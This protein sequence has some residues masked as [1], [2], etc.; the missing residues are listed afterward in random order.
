[1]KA[2]WTDIPEELIATIFSF[3]KFLQFVYPTLSILNRDTLSRILPSCP[4]VE[5][6]IHSLRIIKYRLVLQSKS[7]K[8]LISQYQKIEQTLFDIASQFPNIFAHVRVLDMNRAYLIDYESKPLYYG[9]I[10]TLFPNVERLYMSGAFRNN[11]TPSKLQS[12]LKICP[13]LVLVDLTFCSGDF[14]D[15]DPRFVKFDAVLREGTTIPGIEKAKQTIQNYSLDPFEYWCKSEKGII[16]LFHAACTNFTSMKY[17]FETFHY[18]PNK[19]FED[20][21]TPLSA[22]LR[23]R[24]LS[25]IHYLIKRGANLAHVNKRGFI[26]VLDSE[27]SNMLISLNEFIKQYPKYKECLKQLAVVQDKHGNTI[28]HHLCSFFG[29]FDFPDIAGLVPVLIDDCGAD[30]AAKNNNG[31]TPLSTL[32]GTCSKLSRIHDE[33]LAQSLVQLVDRLIPYSNIT[34][35]MFVD[36]YEFPSQIKW[37]EWWTDTSFLL[38]Q[39]YITSMDD[40]NVAVARLAIHANTLHDLNHFICAREN[41]SDYCVSTDDIV[42]LLNTPVGDNLETFLHF[43]VTRKEM[44]QVF[45]HYYALLDQTA[46]NAK[47]ETALDIAFRRRSC[48]HIVRLCDMTEYDSNGMT[49]LH[50]VASDVGKVGKR[51]LSQ[52][53]YFLN[54]VKCVDEHVLQMYTNDGRA[55]TIVHLLAQSWDDIKDDLEVRDQAPTRL[56]LEGIYRRCLKSGAKEVPNANGELPRDIMPRVEI[57]NRRDPEKSIYFN[58][59]NEEWKYLK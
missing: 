36:F 31:E 49:L 23:L 20:G 44:S 34:A 38:M 39:K 37:K 40:K 47:G 30:P 4:P 55:N 24:E 28:L 50:R 54:L 6:D 9:R 35:E 51:I 29:C 25:S 10:L 15:Y 33:A 42:S 59:S 13:K 53:T 5:I 43:E 22:V 56:A 45:S 14:N 57:L 21:S 52:Q 16:S 19:E 48:E 8:N 17:C 41:N 32:L 3:N 26:S 11:C 2:T 7:K 46:Q 12:K 27:S 1:M 58:K 18:D